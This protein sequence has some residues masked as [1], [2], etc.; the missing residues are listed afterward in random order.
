MV[1]YEI[2]VTRLAVIITSSA[3]PM[4]RTRDG[5]ANLFVDAA[6]APCPPATV[7][8]HEWDLYRSLLREHRFSCI[9]NPR[10]R[11]RCRPVP[12]VTRSVA[13]LV[14]AV[15][16]PNTRCV[17][18]RQP[19]ASL[20]ANGT[21]DVENRTTALAHNEE[22]AHCWIL[23]VASAREA[24]AT[25]WQAAVRDVQRRIFWNH[26]CESPSAATC[27]TSRDD[28]PYQSV[29]ALAR[30]RC[31]GPK[32]SGQPWVGKQS[33]WNNGDTY[34]WQVLEVHALQT[35][36]FFGKG[37]QTPAVYATPRDGRNGGFFARIRAEV[38][39]AFAAEVCS[40]SSA[41]VASI[42][43]GAPSL[44]DLGDGTRAWFFD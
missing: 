23:I 21:K 30:V 43:R 1:C 25:K 24:S 9:R 13:E 27:P 4:K 2:R 6:T 29:V 17:N 7:S 36:I 26:G 37:F 14:A 22:G 39:C 8:Q 19:F 32:A 5:Q 28:Y 11:R 40:Q 15:D 20:L 34:A 42:T 10:R 33:V 41:G 12:P 16:H 38:K 35:P 31:A 44:R 3:V 18:V